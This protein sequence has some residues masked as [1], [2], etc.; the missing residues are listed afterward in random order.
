MRSWHRLGKVKPQ[1]AVDHAQCHE[2]PAQPDMH[3]S[4]ED[5]LGMSLEISMVGNFGQWLDQHEAQDTQSD[6]RMVGVKLAEFSSKLVLPNS[7]EDDRA[8][9]GCIHTS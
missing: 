6:Y 7:S 2:N 8:G 5:N 1:P 4:K 3:V 9:G